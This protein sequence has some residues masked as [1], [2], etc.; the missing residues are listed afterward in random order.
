M[1]RIDT[2]YAH[3]ACGA[4]AVLFQ[5]KWRVEI[6]CAMRSGPVRIGQLSRVIPRA[7]KKML[8][9]NLRQLEADGIVVRH[10]MS[11]VVLHVEYDFDPEVR[12]E[13][14]SLLDHLAHWGRFYATSRATSSEDDKY[15]SK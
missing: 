13:V 14:C 7:S 2:R 8:T 15:L 9:Q 5:A 1:S 6:L 3:C 4:A 12:E 11:E 10:D